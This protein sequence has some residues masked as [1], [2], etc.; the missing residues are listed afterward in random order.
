MQVVGLTGN[1]GSGKSTVAKA[2]VALG[3]PVFNSDDE[4]KKAYL[5]PS[6]QNEVKEIL[7]SPKGPME[8]LK[9]GSPKGPSED[10]YLDF[11]KDTWKFEIA[12]IIFS[13]EE[14]R[15][16]LETL[17]HAFVQNEFIRWKATQNSKYI[18]RESA[19]ANSFQQENCNWLIEVLAEKET[20]KKRVMQR[21]GLSEN[22]FSKR[23]E[24][25]KSNDSFPPEKTFRIQNNENNFVLNEIMKIHEQLSA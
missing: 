2:F 25:Q 13:N 22:E 20:R 5:I 1:I 8:G 7:G 19:L 16:R 11:S 9:E 15:L 24:L 23:D 18:I 12:E 4:A 17:I 3:I 6:I 21:S 14:K 10:N